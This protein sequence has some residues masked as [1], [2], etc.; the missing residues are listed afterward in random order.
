MGLD[1]IVGLRQHALAKRLLVAFDDRNAFIFQARECLLLDREQLVLVDPI[2]LEDWQAKG[3][4]TRTV[5]E[6]TQRELGQT[7]FERGKAAFRRNEWAAAS[8]DLSRFL[9]MQPTEPEQIEADHDG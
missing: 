9:A 5:D 2:G 6:W 3:V 1:E 7:A 8:E 4:P